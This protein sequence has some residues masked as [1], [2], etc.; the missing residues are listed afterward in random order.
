MKE[1]E[2]EKPKRKAIII[3]N[4]P[5]TAYYKPILIHGQK[6]DSVILNWHY[7]H[8]ATAEYLIKMMKDGAGWMEVNGSRRRVTVENTK[9]KY[10]DLKT[11]MCTCEKIK[12]HTH[13]TEQI[14]MKCKQYVQEQKTI[15]EVNEVILE[16]VAQARQQ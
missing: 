10:K 9:C 2:Q 5:D 7:R 1:D 3:G 6:Y 16:K 13:C 4:K 12:N 8:A 11:G 14:R 15:I